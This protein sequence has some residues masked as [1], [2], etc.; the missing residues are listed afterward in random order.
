MENHVEVA[1]SAIAPTTK[2]TAVIII[3]FFLLRHLFRRFR[4]ANHPAIFTFNGGGNKDTLFRAVCLHHLAAGERYRKLPKCGHCF[5]VHCIDA[6]LQA[7]PTCPICRT[8]V[9]DLRL[10]RQENQD[11]NYVSNFLSLP[12]KILRRIGNPFDQEIATALCV[13]LRYIH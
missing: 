4:V 8:P 1:D 9:L 10:P 7:H 2:C 6:W 13:N 3:A 5:H 11:R 12:G